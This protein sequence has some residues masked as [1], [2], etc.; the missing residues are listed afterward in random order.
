MKDLDKKAYKA[1]ANDLHLKVKKLESQN[2][3]TIS[4]IKGLDDEIKSLKNYHSEQLTEKQICINKN[5]ALLEERDT[6]I[7]VLY[8]HTEE[9]ANAFCKYKDTQK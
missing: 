9:M 6:L 2:K 7:A 5:K 1:L 4:V 3:I 8:H